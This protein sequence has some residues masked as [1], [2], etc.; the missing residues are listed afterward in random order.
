M[1]GAIS[2]QTSDGAPPS[3]TFSAPGPVKR[4]SWDASEALPGTQSVF[5]TK[6][7]GALMQC[8]AFPERTCNQLHGTVHFPAAVGSEPAQQKGLRGSMGV[9]SWATS[10]RDTRLLSREGVWVTA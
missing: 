1:E 7:S 5:L 10:A 2:L 8:T 4:T 6:R 3:G 9:D